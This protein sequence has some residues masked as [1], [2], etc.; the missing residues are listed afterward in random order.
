VCKRRADADM[1]RRRWRHVT[2][3]I[4]AVSE[5]ARKH[6]MT[7]HIHRS[8]PIS[9]IT[10]PIPPIIGTD[11]Q[12]HAGRLLLVSVNVPLAEAATISGHAAESKSGVVSILTE[13][14]LPSPVAALHQS[15]A[16]QR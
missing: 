4:A 5:Q 15:L 3:Y 10:V 6:A 8:V 16:G 12:R 11:S 7:R 1:Q 9:L 13:N 14:S 2:L